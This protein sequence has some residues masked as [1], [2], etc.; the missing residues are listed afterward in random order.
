LELGN[1]PGGEF[2]VVELG[3]ALR[4]EIEHER[5][6]LTAIV[7]AGTTL[8]ELQSVLA[9]QGQWWPVDPPLAEAATVGGVLATGLPGPL[10]TRYGLP[11]DYVLGIDVLR[12]DGERVKAGGRVVKNVTGYDLMRLYCGS[13]GTLG[14]I[15]RVALRVLPKAETVE[16]ALRVESVDEGVRIVREVTRLDLRPEV[17][18]IVVG[19]SGEPV[20]LLRVPAAAERAT[21]TALGRFEEIDAVECYTVARD[22]GFEDGAA[23]TLRVTGTLAQGASVAEQLRK[24]DPSAVAVRPV[25]GTVRATWQTEDM[26]PLRAVEPVVAQMRSRLSPLGGSVVVERLPEGYRGRLDVWGEVPEAFGLMKRTKAAYD[27]DGRLS[28]GRFV[29]GI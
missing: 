8:G 17:A 2:A 21:R 24:L 27:P 9:A 7:W 26:P 13:L 25:G 20:M 28:R 6:D 1:S 10:R 14:I 16:F 23:L 4:G 18:E 15:E 11:R 29:G 22:V 5:D 19:G 12:A 3:E